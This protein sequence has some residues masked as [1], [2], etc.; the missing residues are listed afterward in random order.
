MKV[1]KMKNKFVLLFLMVIMLGIV[2]AE[3][4]SLGTFKQ[5]SCISLKQTCANC[6]YVNITSVLYPNGVQALG[7]VKMTKLASEYNYTYCSTAQIGQYIYNTLGDPDG[8]PTTQPVTFEIT[9]SGSTGLLGISI[10][11][12]VIVY[13]IGF[14]GFFG[15]H[16]WVAVL[17]GMAMIILG[18]YTMTNGLDIFRNTMTNALAWV[19]VGLGAI[20][21]LTAGVELINDN[22]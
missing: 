10:I 14:F 11:I 3:Q 13:A 9:P 5:S 18:L 1:R 2:S 20:F 6:T 17:G 22:L 19:T 16:I 21:A 15:K 12:F 4:Q 7:N 8:I